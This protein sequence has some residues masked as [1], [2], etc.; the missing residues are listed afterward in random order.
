MKEEKIAGAFALTRP[1]NLSSA[2]LNWSQSSTTC[3]TFL[4]HRSRL[5]AFSCTTK[6]RH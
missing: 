4:F 3:S 2:T 6:M 5:L 1:L